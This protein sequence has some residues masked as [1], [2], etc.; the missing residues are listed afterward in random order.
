LPFTS[1]SFSFCC[2]CFLVLVSAIT[3][4]FKSNHDLACL[5]RAIMRK[6]LA[7]LSFY[8]AA[9]VLSYVHP[10]IAL[11]LTLVVAVMYFLPNAWIEKKA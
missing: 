7:A 5:K 11:V 1:A 8:T 2:L 6:N 3:R 10:A 9:A 4:H